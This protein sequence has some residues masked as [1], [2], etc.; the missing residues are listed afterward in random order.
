MAE[1]HK[2]V[3]QPPK[4]S[5]NRGLTD[6]L[7]KLNVDDAAVFSPEEIVDSGRFRVAVH[8]SGRYYGKKYA[9]RV[10]PDRSMVVTRVS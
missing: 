2:N 7:Q 6:V 4:I 5:T 8:A 3:G 10:Q 9:C 1:I